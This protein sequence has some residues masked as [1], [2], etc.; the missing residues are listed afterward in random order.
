ML[1]PPGFGPIGRDP[2]DS[3]EERML[4]RE[5]RGLENERNEQRM[6]GD[7]EGGQDWQV[8]DKYPII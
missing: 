8:H 6:L 4:I 2:N 1:P 3:A 7:P 5:Q